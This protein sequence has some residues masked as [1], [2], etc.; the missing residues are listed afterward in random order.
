LSCVVDAAA[1]FQLEVLRWFI[2]ATR[3]AGIAESDLV[4]HSLSDGPTEALNF[5]EAAGVEIVQIE[6]FD[7]RSPHCNKISG[8]MSLA[9]RGLVGPIVLTD[10]DLAF[11][12]D[13]RHL[14]RSAGHIVGKTVDR[15]NPP[16]EVLRG[17]FDHVGFHHPREVPLEW[18]PE[19]MTMATNLNGG[20]YVIDGADLGGLAQAWG[21]WAR[22]LLDRPELLGR[23]ALHVDQVAMALAITA[24]AMEPELITARWNF[25][26]HMPALIPPNIGPPEILHY[27]RA[28][29]GIGRLQPPGVL[30]VD[31]QVRVVNDAISE[32]WRDTFPNQAFWDWRYSSNPELGS[33]VGSRGNALARK[34]SLLEH[35]DSVLKQKTVLD[36]GCGDGEATRG[37]FSGPYVGLDVSA[38]ALTTARRGRTHGTFVHGSLSEHAPSAELTICLDVLIHQSEY[39]SYIDLVGRLLESTTSILL[40]SGYETPPSASSPMIH[41]HEPLSES[42]RR[43]LPDAE[44]YPLSAINEA[45]IHL[46]VMPTPQGHPRDFGS[47]TLRQVARRHPAALRLVEMRLV[48]RRTVGFYPDHSPRLWEYPAV[49]EK[50]LQ[51]VPKHALIA[52]IGAGVNPLVPFLSQRGLRVHT[53][54]PSS[55]RRLWPIELTA[56]EWGFLDYGEAGLGERSWNCT[57]QEIDD[58]LE[59]D[60]MYS[61]SVIEHLPAVD[62][63]ELLFEISRRLHPGGLLVLTVDIVRGTE[64]LWNR[65]EG[66]DVDPPGEHGDMDSVTDEATAAGLLPVERTII[67]DWGDVPVDIGWLVFRRTAGSQAPAS[68]LDRVLGQAWTAVRPFV[69]ERARA[70]LFP[71]FRRTYY[72]VFPGGRRPRT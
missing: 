45:V 15:P 12:A 70:A 38:E 2:T 63:R 42:I 60:L 25:P 43:H 4:V 61:V 49:A 62:R 28:L 46:V 39:A 27:H 8:A 17:V 57:L 51:A 56:N 34:R 55:L 41:Y 6:R 36:V 30:P 13:P 5:L 69:P 14:A 16:L 23:W 35:V 54:D 48:A 64:N 22:Y 52:D 29:D 7:D 59:F 21:H 10:S 3:C 11:L 66:R 44:L 31:R 37:L 26:T 71:R 72:R 67:R 1:G 18:Q 58:E 68:W 32:L 24:T 47:A 19:E 40:V 50:V 53:I 20:L 9:D 33:G 65:S